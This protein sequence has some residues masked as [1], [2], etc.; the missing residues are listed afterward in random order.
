[1]KRSNPFRLVIVQA[2]MGSTRLP[3]KVLLEL[4]GRPLLG[5][6]IERLRQA[7]KPDMTVIATTTEP[8]DDAIAEL[9]RREGWECFRGHP[10]DLLD[11][12]LQC[13]RAYCATIVAKVPSDVPV[14]DPAVV[15]EVFALY[16]SG[17]YDYVS[18]LH[19]PSFPDGLDCEVFSV[20][21]LEVAAREATRDFEREHTTPFLW[22]NPER[23]R[24]GNVATPDGVNYFPS[25]RWTID[26]EEDY[27]F[28]Q[29]IFDTLYRGNPT[30]SWQ[31]LMAFLK[32]RPDITALNA[33]LNGV[34][35]YRHYLDKLKHV[36]KSWV[37]QSPR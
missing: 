18:N 13:A 10:T 32:T 23:F 3:G 29:A 12:H 28:L 35:W 4:A 2:R 30:F 19:P 34:V 20:S 25:H 7:R 14:V 24:I 36:D 1:M 6:M 15:D 27:R 17:A 33:H 26:Y 21:A 37:R 11:R 9:C 22:D 16:E 5:R 8:A 31:D